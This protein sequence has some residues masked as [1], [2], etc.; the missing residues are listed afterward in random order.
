MKLK[1]KLF[2]LL[3][4]LSI[5]GIIAI[6]PYTLTL[7]GGLP[8]NLPVPLYVLLSAQLIQNAVL[9]AV[10][11]LFGL[12]LAK[13]VGLELPVLSGWLEGKPIKEYL[14]SILSISIGLGLVAGAL[15]IGLDYLFSLAG[16]VINTPL[17]QQLPPAWQGFLASFYGGI[18]EEILLRLFFMS[19]LVWISFKIKK[20]DL[21]NQLKLVFGLPLYC[22]QLYLE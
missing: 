18:N 10:V 13:R 16:S 6:L 21:E 17:S 7:Q 5:W 3:L 19:L 2:F 22:L 20:S 12:E 8:P 14:K 9:F 11:I 1:W 4:A 15:I